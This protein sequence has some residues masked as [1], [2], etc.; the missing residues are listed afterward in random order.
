ME[1]EH[2]NPSDFDAPCAVCHV[3]G[4]GDQLMIPGRM[5]C[6][7]GWTEEYYGMLVSSHFSHQGA[8]YECLDKEPE[9]VL[10]SGVNHNGGLFYRVEAACG[11]SLPCP[12]YVNGYE[13]TCV[14]CTI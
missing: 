10:N 11:G 3:T 9:A 7:F 4:R 1:Y 14:V 5:S 12:P 8:T 6:P 13:L 2:I